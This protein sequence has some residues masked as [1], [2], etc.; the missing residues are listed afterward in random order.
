MAVYNNS[1]RQEVTKAHGAAA[2]MKKERF[3]LRKGLD[4]MKRIP[5]NQTDRQDSSV[6]LCYP[7][8]IYIRRALPMGFVGGA[9]LLIYFHSYTC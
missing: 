3:F 7:S 1:H 8:S 9:R 5:H 4:S 2:A 6:L